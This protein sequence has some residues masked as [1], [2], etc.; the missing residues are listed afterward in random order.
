[1]IYMAYLAIHYGSLQNGQ[2]PCSR[3]ST[4]TAEFL[5]EDKSDV[6]VVDDVRIQGYHQYQSISLCRTISISCAEERLV[7]LLMIVNSAP[8]TGILSSVGR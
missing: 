7:S 4:S 6:H 1:M 5:L 8:R 2:T 3:S